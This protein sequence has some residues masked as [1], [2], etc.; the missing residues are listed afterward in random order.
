MAKPIPYDDDDAPED[1]ERDM[2]KIVLYDDEA[3]KLMQGWTGGTSDPLYAISSM[4]GWNYA[5]VFSD[6]IANIDRDLHSV[7]KIGRNK[8]QL[9]KG[10]F[11]KAEIDE[12]RYIR[13]ELSMALDNPDNVMVDEARKVRASRGA[14]GTVRATPKTD[15]RAYDFF[16]RHAGYGYGPGETPEQGRKKGAAALAKAEQE[17]TARGWTVKWEEDPEGWDS[18]GDI[19]PDD[20]REILS[21]V[22]YDEDGKVLESLGGIVNP[23]RNYSRVVEAELALE[24]LP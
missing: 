24:A 14:S 11:S 8:F 19:D 5:W 1:D 16:Y 2:R 17:A 21:A 10:T 3:L 7:K 6:A 22:L 13:D 20:V 12:L 23:D 15:R 9:G 18:I 4:G